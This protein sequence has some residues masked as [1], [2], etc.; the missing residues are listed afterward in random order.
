MPAAKRRA[1][2]HLQSKHGYPQRRAC[3]LMDCN[4][5]TARHVSTRQDDPVLRERLKVLADE[6]RAWGYRMLWG[7]LR[8]EEIRVN[9]KRVYRLYKE[10]KLE[11]RPRGRKRLKGEKKG[12]PPAPT[13]VNEVYNMDFMSDVLSDGRPFRILNVLDAF[14]RQ[15]H[16]IEVDTSLGG[17]RVVR[18][19]T[20]VFRLHGKPQRLQ[21]DNGP[22]FRCKL[23]ERWARKEGIQLYFIDPGKPNQNNRIESFNGRFREECLNQEWFASLSEARQITGNWRRKYNEQRPHSSL[24]YLSPDEWTRR[25]RAGLIKQDSV[26][27]PVPQQRAAGTEINPLSLLPPVS[28]QG[29]NQ[30]QIFSDRLV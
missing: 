9:H 28:Y 29:D 12:H 30:T 17:Y 13:T 25:Y 26:I 5:M 11:H 8:M 7:K 2:Q 19:L 27:I 1:V 15:C 18:T 24:K 16:A 3:G 22:E 21:I 6:N 4:R 23:L 20:E 10:E 14:T